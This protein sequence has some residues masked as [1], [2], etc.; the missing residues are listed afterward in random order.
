M[1]KLLKVLMLALTIVAASSFSL[2]AKKT[3]ERSWVLTAIN[4]HPIADQWVQ[5]KTLNPD[6]TFITLKSTDSGKTFQRAMQGTWKT[7]TDG[8]CIET[9]PNN[10]LTILTY[11]F[12]KGN[13]LTVSYKWGNQTVTEQ[14]APYKKK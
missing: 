3:L 1:K 4:G 2:S 10:D 13:T 12:G 11:E 9:L 8:I 7:V 14:W 5:I 6:H